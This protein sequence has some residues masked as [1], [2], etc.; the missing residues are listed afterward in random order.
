MQQL[1]IEQ[2][3]FMG[4]SCRVVNV[5]KPYTTDARPHIYYSVLLHIIIAAVLVVIVC[6]LDLQ[7]PFT[8]KV[9]S[10]NPFHSEVYSIQHYVI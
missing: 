5:A 8:I 1:T 7:L 6:W 3:K 4:I 10:S 9:V 2:N